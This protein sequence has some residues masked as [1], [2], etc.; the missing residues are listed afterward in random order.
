MG[1]GT[2]DYLP[3]MTREFSEPILHVDMDA[4]FVEVER[5]HDSS[6]KG[7]PV[8]VGGSGA[9]GVVAAASYEARAYGVH[10]AM[11]MIEARR[12]CPQAVVVPPSHGRYGEVSK[13]V[14][15]IFRSFTPKVEGLSVDEAFLDVAGLRLHY[16]TP[17][18][19]AESIRGRIR[20]DLDLPASVGIAANKFL[21]KLASEEAKPDGLFRVAAGSELDFLHPLPVRRLWGVGE[22]TY[23][24]LEALGV[25]TVGDLAATP[26]NLVSQRVGSAV[27][28]HL[29]E[30]AHGRDPRPVEGGAGAKS[31][32]AEATYGQ[33]LVSDEAIERAVLR[34]CDRLSARLRR[35][36]YAGRTI[37]VKLRFGDFTTVTRSE[38]VP[39]AIEHTS[40]LW[41]VARALLARIDH[42]GRGVR[43]LGV[44]AGNL[45]A[46]SDPRQLSMEHPGRDAAAEAAEQVR[47]RFGDDAVVP[48]R[49]V[50]TPPNPTR[51][52]EEGPSM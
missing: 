46:G 43:L 23:A 50:D 2:W 49:L 39:V 13:Q 10:S 30:L 40:D 26:E 32:S 34:H 11:P 37:T 21:A 27:G 18:D 7:R 4:F 15:D 12:R 41:D 33:D 16:D 42:G 24:A 22:A 48:A 20:S 31:I 47:A 1:L 38:T 45:V 35:Q 14:F 52:G 19:V 28:R 9:R 29:L 44:G 25:R 8:V 36:G 3:P 17:V 5:L 51:G 6:L